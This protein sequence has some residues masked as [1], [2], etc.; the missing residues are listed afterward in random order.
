M[1]NIVYWFIPGDGNFTLA[2]ICIS[3]NSV[4][5]HRDLS[6]Q[7]SVYICHTGLGENEQRV[8]GKFRCS[9]FNILFHKVNNLM[10]VNGSQH[11]FACI[12]KL[13]VLRSL[14]S[15]LDKAV[16]V[17]MDVLVRTDIAYFYD[18]ELNGTVFAAFKDYPVHKVAKRP[19]DYCNVGFCTVDIDLFS[20]YDIGSWQRYMDENTWA[21]QDAMNKF[22]PHVTFPDDMMSFTGEPNPAI[23]EN[24]IESVCQAKVI[25]YAGQTKGFD[26]RTLPSLRDLWASYLPAFCRP[27]I[28]VKGP[29]VVALGDSILFTD[30]IKN[31]E[32]VFPGFDIDIQCTDN[33]VEVLDACGC[34]YKR[35]D[36]KYN[37]GYWKVIDNPCYFRNGIT[38]GKH[39]L[40]QQIIDMCDRSGLP[41]KLFS[42]PVLSR[43]INDSSYNT[44]QDYVIVPSFE[45]EKF[46]SV[47]KS[48]HH[49]QKFVKLLYDNGYNVFELNTWVEHPKTFLYSRG[50]LYTKSLADSAKILKNAK[51][52]V[53]TENGLNHWACHNGAKSYCLLLSRDRAHKEEL[54]YKTMVPVEC[55]EDDSAEHVMS[56]I[57][58]HEK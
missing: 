5:L 38:R 7:Y 39:L 1:C 56:V 23:S 6:R 11:K 42:R 33:T 43:S 9:G 2:D 4:K 46:S 31:L 55:Y 53:T 22:M 29:P 41:K 27:R 51:F 57:K 28:F 26:L 45:P 52:V 8:L 25:H 30:V 17:D 19:E 58:E 10:P 35:K 54:T 20:E 15:E 24:Q 32:L 14:Q 40:A 16:M 34:K 50:I 44:P 48:W 36:D 3:I 47:D 49:W 12:N 21:D 18:Y 13:M 37:G